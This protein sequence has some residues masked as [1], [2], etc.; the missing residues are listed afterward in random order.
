[1]AAALGTIAYAMPTAAGRQHSIAA[2]E[3]LE[4]GARL[5]TNA[6]EG[7][8]RREAQKR[9]RTKEGEGGG[10]GGG[11]GALQHLSVKAALRDAI[12]GIRAGG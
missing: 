11:G 5:R 8:T 12:R 2:T 3:G 4:I 7:S 9:G 1:M 6:L 10:G